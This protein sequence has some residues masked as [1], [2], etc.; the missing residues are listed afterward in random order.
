MHH[1]HQPIHI[2]AGCV[3]YNVP[4][5]YYMDTRNVVSYVDTMHTQQISILRNEAQSQYETSI[6]NDDQISLP[7]IAQ[8]TQ[9]RPIHS[10]R[11]HYHYITRQTTNRSILNIPNHPQPDT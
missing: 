3:P 6:S 10:L 1:K 7:L 2:S 11:T 5:P 4:K 9:E 8:G